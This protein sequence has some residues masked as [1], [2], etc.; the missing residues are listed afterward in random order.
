MTADQMAE[1]V[2]DDTLEKFGFVW[3]LG[4]IGSGGTGPDKRI[5]GQTPYVYIE[6]VRKFDET[7]PGIA[8]GAMNGTSIK[9]TCQDVTRTLMEK[10]QRTPVKEMRTAVI[11]RLRGVKARSTTVV[12][13]R[14]YLAIDGTEFNSAAEA[15]EYS[16]LLLS[17]PQ[18]E[19]AAQEVEEVTE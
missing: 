5:L 9:V 8:Q 12:E 17:E 16:K 13:K 2:S 10:N 11:N 1:M 18:A 4:D 15:T 14:I 19:V 7:F 3:K 6:N